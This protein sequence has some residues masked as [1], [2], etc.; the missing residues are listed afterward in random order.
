M[1]AYYARFVKYKTKKP[2]R[3]CKNAT[4]GVQYG[5]FRIRPWRN[6]IS[7]WIPIPKAGGSSPSGRAKKEDVAFA[8]SSFLAR[9]AQNP[10]AIL[11][12]K[13]QHFSELA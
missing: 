9:R 3:G 12:C 10:H 11:R 7:Q 6:W 4:D 1:V 13:M 2:K 8:A 5:M